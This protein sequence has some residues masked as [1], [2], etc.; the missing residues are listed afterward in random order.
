MSKEHRFVFDCSFWIHVF[1]LST[2]CQ[3]KQ[4]RQFDSYP[5]E[6][7][8]THTHCLYH[9]MCWVFLLMLNRLFSTSPQAK[10]QNFDCKIWNFF[11]QKIFLPQKCIGKL[12]ITLITKCF[13]KKS[14]SFG[15]DSIEYMRMINT[16]YQKYWT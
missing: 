14:V 12:K 11:R 4:M 6:H 1:V 13:N 10:F 3:V 9:V 2:M 5:H 15:Q 7:A 8:R 16:F